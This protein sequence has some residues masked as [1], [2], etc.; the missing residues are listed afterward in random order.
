MPLITGYY[1]TQ[2]GVGGSAVLQL[3]YLGCYAC[4]QSFARQP[5]GI[6]VVVI[7]AIGE[8]CMHGY[9]GYVPFHP[10]MR[11]TLPTDCLL[12]EYRL[13]ILWKQAQL[14]DVLSNTSSVLQPHFHS[15]AT[16]IPAA[17]ASPL[18]V[19]VARR[20]CCDATASS[21]HP[22]STSWRHSI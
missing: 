20:P 22:G 7:H 18:P 5:M 9:Y 19:S 17:P 1:V 16:H 21:L 11:L 14:I 6:H 10:P 3:P 4:R 12:M 8:P 13:W 2:V 15:G